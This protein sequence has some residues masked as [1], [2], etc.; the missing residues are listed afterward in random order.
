[1]IFFDTFDNNIQIDIICTYICVLIFISKFLLVCE[2]SNSEIKFGK[3]VLL[4]AKFSC[5]RAVA[6]HVAQICNVTS[7]KKYIEAL[8]STLR[9][10]IF[11][12]LIFVLNAF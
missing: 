5:K 1:M 7:M 6:T 12:R 10:I 9:F 2:T 4:S 8:Y 11:T 3:L